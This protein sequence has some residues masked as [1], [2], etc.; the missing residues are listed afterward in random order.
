GTGF[1]AS[2][3]TLAF[4]AEGHRVRA[5]ARSQ[6]KADRWNAYHADRHDLSNLSWA[7]VE[8]IAKPG[9]FDRAIEGVDILAHTASPFHY[10]IKDVERDMLVP[11]LQ[12]TRAA[13][14]AAQRE[15]SV[16]RVVVTSSFAAV[17]DFAKLGPET[18][19]SE[20]DWNPATYESAKQMDPSKDQAQIYCA[21][22]VIAEQEAWKIAREPETQFALSTVCPPL[23]FGPPQQPIDSMDAI[24]TSSGAVW[25]IVDS[26]QVPETSFPVW[27]DVRDIAKIH[28]LAT[29][30]DAGKGQRYLTIA[31]HFD[32]AQIADFGRQAFPDAAA[33]F[34]PA[35]S[36]PARDHF[37]TD[38]SK[39]ERELGVEFMPFRTSVRDTLAELFKIEQRLKRD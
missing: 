10:D 36:K 39:V 5:T 15:P 32:N 31:G 33:R 16:K 4:L 35:D 24:N 29:T 9:A 20:R 34:P 22:K 23:I 28:V 30:R 2:A 7:I 6:A 8:D 12:G 26:D 37:K 27:T 38:S 14:R 19:F 11:A 25:S 21:S 18:T 1:V 3:V 13:L 17:L